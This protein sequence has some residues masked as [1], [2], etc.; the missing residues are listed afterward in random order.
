MDRKIVLAFV[1]MLLLLAVSG[2]FLGLNTVTIVY[3]TNALEVDEKFA[4]LS[5]NTIWVPDNYTA[6]Q[7]AINAASPG[8]TIR[9]RAGTY[10]ENVVVNK[11]LSLIGEDKDSTIIDANDADA[12]LTIQANS[13]T[14][15]GFIIQ[16]GSFGII[17][18]GR[19][20][21]E[22]CSR[23]N[24]TGNIIRSNELGLYI[25]GKG[26]NTI[27]NNVM[28][29]N[30]FGLYIGSSNNILRDNR[31][32]ENNYNFIG[33][34][35]TYGVQS[36]YNDI[37][38][39]NTVDGKP[40][41]Y[42]VDQTNLNINP[43]NF[44]NIG[45]LALINCSNIAVRDLT[46]T[47]NGEGILL[48][49]CINCTIEG[50]MIRDNLVA[51]PAYTNNTS[52][53]NN[54]ISGN[55][56]GITLM[57]YHNQIENN[58]IANNTVRLAPY[59]WPEAWPHYNPVLFWITQY[60]L[61]WYSGGLYL[62]HADNNTIIDNNIT[63]NEHGILLFAS[64]FNVFK[65]NSLIGN[66]YNFGI[67][68]TWLCPPEWV[69]HPPEPPQISPFLIND[70]DESNTVN[71]KPIYW[72]INRHNEQIPTDAGYVILVN[73]TDMVIK[74]LVLQ[75]NTQ[76]MLLVDVNNIV[77]S[78]NIISGTRYGVLMRSTVHV[79]GYT[80]VNTTITHNNITKNGVGIESVSTN[81]TFSHN[82]L[83]H[84][85]AGIYD[86]GEGYNLIVGNNITNNVFPPIEEWILE[87]EPP[88]SVPIVYYYA[89]AH[90]VLLAS[91]NNTIC[92]NNIQN[93]DYG[94]STDIVTKRGED[95]DI[96]HNN[97]INNTMQA[98]IASVN[99]W[100]L[101]YPSGG[102]YWSD[103]NGT[104]THWGQY[105][106][107]IGSDG[108]GDRQY[109]LAK[110]CSPTVPIEV[111]A[112]D[113]EYPL[114]APISIF[115]AGTWDNITFHVDIISNSIVSDLQF[116]PNEGAFLKFN[117]TGEDGT[118]GL[119]RVTIPKSLL[120]VED[121]W[122]VTVN[123]E[124][125]NYTIIPDENFTYLYFAYNHSTKT[126]RVQGTSVIPEFPSTII[127]P[128]FMAFTILAVVFAKRIFPRRP[129][130]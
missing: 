75:N 52:F 44:P 8:D 66:V 38:T 97:F 13:T 113:D 15:E 53:S 12:V 121:G 3:S 21:Y 49:Q 116:D 109:A 59:R 92:Y 6:I 128:L 91:A 14:V 77:V 118:T 95:N 107:Q 85:L 81:S 89:G 126:V 16:N 86:R 27:V 70:V 32:L 111:R 56:H 48:S 11:T 108:I 73:S 130:C 30:V 50:N 42:L 106:N 25:S 43:S 28:T 90:G 39:S 37:D 55:Y 61:M 24:I 31:M 110:Y 26:N 98:L 20:G 112:Q 102:N 76:G 60:G 88:H 96:H 69:I 45:Y 5:S 57:G 40:V 33:V 83:S 123:E 87:Y 51:I 7:E 23:N 34:L 29:N 105:Q 2:V 10:Y 67:D 122:N 58:T 63:N 18:I 1:S 127:L 125:V 129:K 54:F 65:N 82:I 94:L 74:N 68:T 84:N 124:S 17:I 62:W 103:Y 9:V 119:C 71:G 47:N 99:K 72:W 117:A 22:P 80:L 120:W 78:N 115:D 79:Y 46:L 41:Y 35:L 114:M 36:T 64:S 104:D 19:Y 100:D 4:T 101:G 93:N